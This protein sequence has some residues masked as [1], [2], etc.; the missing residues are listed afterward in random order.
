MNS[1]GLK[2]KIPKFNGQQ[3]LLSRWN[4]E[5]VVYSRRYSFDVVFTR[6]NECQDV[7]VGDSDCPMGR[8]EDEFEANIVVSHLNA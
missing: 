6:V 4:M 1:S 2:L 5:S 3:K 8:L 7:S